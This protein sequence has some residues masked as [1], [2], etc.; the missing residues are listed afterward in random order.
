MQTKKE[1][2]MTNLLKSE[3]KEN[4]EQNN[5]QKINECYL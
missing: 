3:K 2:E 4:D 1:I 5:K